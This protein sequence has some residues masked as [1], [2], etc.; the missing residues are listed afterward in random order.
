MPWFEHYLYFSPVYPFSVPLFSFYQPWMYK[1]G[2]LPPQDRQVKDAD[3]VGEISESDYDEILAMAHKYLRPHTVILVTTP[4][5]NN[6]IHDGFQKLRKDNEA[7]RS[8]VQN[9][10][11]PKNPEAG[12]QNVLLLDWEKLIDAA[13]LANAEILGIQPEMAFQHSL[14]GVNIEESKK[15]A[16][17]PQLTAMTCSGS[18]PT[19]EPQWDTECPEDRMG[20]I[21]PDGM[22]LCGATLGP[23]SSGG[24]AC[25][26]KCAIDADGYDFDERIPLLSQC[27][28][29]CNRLFMNMNTIFVADNDPA[30]SG[31]L[32]VQ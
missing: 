28:N 14:T 26:M 31:R 19:K 25:L 4:V 2:I 16:W 15:R 32:E 21:S 23:R 8:Y 1:E 29:A 22:H 17:Y 18:T 3:I 24:L 5:N 6:G 27:Q 12:I 20:R 7:I 30:R 11:P 9:F 13:I 10:V